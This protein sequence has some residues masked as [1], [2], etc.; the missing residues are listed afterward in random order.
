M[1]RVTAV[2]AGDVGGTN[3]RLALYPGGATEPLL[4]RVYPSA[5]FEG[6][7]PIVARFLKEASAVAPH[8]DVRRAGFGVAG[9]ADGAVVKFTNLP[10]VVRTD[11]LAEAFG[12]DRVVFVNDFAAICR[13]VPHLAPVHLVSLGGGIPHPDA[14]KAVLGAGT[15]LGVGFLVRCG[16]SYRVVASEGGHIDFAPRGPLQLRLAQFLATQRDGA[17]VENI[18]SGRGLANLY[19]FL[20]D[21]EGVAEAA[22][23][24]AATEREDPAAV[25]SAHALAGT[26]PLC[27]RTLELFCEVYG[28][29]AATLA[30]LVMARGG[31]YVAGGIAG[32]IRARLQ[33]GAFRNAF[34][35]HVR[36]TEFLRSVPRYLI[37]HPQPGLLGAAL[38]AQDEFSG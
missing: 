23:V 16:P 33:D 18:L 22:A 2:L 37:S 20:R 12:L 28:A 21:S 13:A 19:A 7:Q 8:V 27:G 36:Y 1:G 14:P 24:R 4:L 6:L 17:Y 26:D 29:V 11:A 9:P 35:Q 31:V 15:G 10:W 32:H 34:E 25:I 3:T 5:A 30:L 38:A